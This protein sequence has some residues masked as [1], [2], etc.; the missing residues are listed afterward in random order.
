MIMCDDYDDC[1][2]GGD[3]TLETTQQVCIKNVPGLTGSHFSE[4][5]CEAL[6]GFS[7]CMR[8]RA[9]GGCAIMH[10]KYNMH[11]VR[12]RVLYFQYDI[13]DIKRGNSIF[14]FLF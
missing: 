1:E 11:G 7:M 4:F 13:F 2:N 12:L 8:N 14:F 6:V 10:E 5:K 9:A 3:Q